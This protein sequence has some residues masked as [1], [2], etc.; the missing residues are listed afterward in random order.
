MKITTEM[1][2]RELGITAAT[3]RQMML[4]GEL[5]IGRIAGS[6]KKRSYVIFPKALYEA[7]GIKLGY[8]PPVEIEYDLL[9]E[10][11]AEKMKEVG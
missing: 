3:V 1:V 4:D 5:N 10:K 9:A 6:E 7:T 2:G 11:I 8:E